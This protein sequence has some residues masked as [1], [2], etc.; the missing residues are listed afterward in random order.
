MNRT[1]DI[2]DMW[3]GAVTST[4]FAPKAGGGLYEARW[5]YRMSRIGVNTTW[6][7]VEITGDAAKTVEAK[8]IPEFNHAAEPPANSPWIVWGVDLHG[9]DLAGHNMAPYPYARDLASPWQVE[10]PA[11]VYEF[12]PTREFQ[13]G[14]D[15]VGPPIYLIN[16]QGEIDGTCT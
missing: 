15:L 16:Q 7:V 1:G 3:L 4:E 2:V 13:P 6:A 10:F 5:I 14:A 8:N 12:A 9:P 11:M